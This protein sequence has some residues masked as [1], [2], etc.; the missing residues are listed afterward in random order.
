[1][2]AAKVVIHVVNRQRS[3]MMF[4]LLGECVRQPSEASHMHPH[5]EILALDKTSADVLRIR[6]A[7]LGASLATNALCWRIAR[8]SRF[9]VS[10]VQLHEHR[11]VDVIMERA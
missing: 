11:I 2:N 1:M 9:R 7:D 6:I 8:V 10:A 5:R 4:D 3:N